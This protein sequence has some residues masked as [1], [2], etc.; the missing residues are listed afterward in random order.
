MRIP[1]QRDI[2]ILHALRRG[3]QF[4]RGRAGGRPDRGATT[5]ISTVKLAQLRLAG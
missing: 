5:T 2:A 3:D 4:R 1:G